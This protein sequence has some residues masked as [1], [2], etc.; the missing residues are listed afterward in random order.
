MDEMNCLKKTAP[1]FRH[2]DAEYF[3]AYKGDEIVGRVAAIINTV[4]NHDWK[5]NVVRF[6]WIDFIDDYEVSKA[7]I[8]AVVK[9]GKERGMTYIKGPLGFSDM[10]KEGLLVEGFENI[11]SIT[12]IYNYPYYAD[13]LERMGFVKDVD[14]TQDIMDIPETLSDKLTR[15]EEVIKERYGYTVMYPKRNSEYR[16]RGKEIFDVMNRS[17]TVLYEYSRLND[18]QI[19]DYVN[20]YLPFVSRDLVCIILDK[21]DK[22]VGFAVT[23]P[24]LSKAFR[25]ANGKLFPF[26]F[27]HILRALK[28]NDLLEALLIGID[29]EHQGKGLSAVIFNHILRGAKKYGLKKMVMNPRLEENRKVRAIF[30]E[31]KPQL[32]MRRRCYKATL[33]TIEQTISTSSSVM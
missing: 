17:F 18:E 20:Q 11:P 12:C 16:K 9:W 33:E 1:A 2:C 8:D 24:S 28:R 13:H 21:N 15:F 27:I 5:E 3:L 30:D 10:D 32:F 31:F 19:Q 22:I 14:W 23:I 4:A 29:P 6:G 7:L 25:K 26:G